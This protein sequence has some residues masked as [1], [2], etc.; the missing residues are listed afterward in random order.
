[1]E[2]WSDLSYKISKSMKGELL[3]V[4][5]ILLLLGCKRPY[6]ELFLQQNQIS[7]AQPRIQRANTIIDSFVI[8]KVDLG[9]EDADIYYTSDGSQPTTSSVKYKAPFKV[10]ENNTYKFRAFHANW[11]A[12]ET[13]TMTFYKKG[14]VPD[15]IIWFSKENMKYKGEGSLTLI[16][17]KKAAL[18]FNNPQWV[19]FDSIV[20]AKVVFKDK[21]MIKSIDIG[22]LSDPQSWIFPPS[23]I[24]VYIDDT[25]KSSDKITSQINEMLNMVPSEM[26]NINLE[27]NREVKSIRLEINNLQSIPKW[28]DGSGNRAWLFM[29]EWI[30][31]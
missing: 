7:L 2:F 6:Q 24:I 26:G 20:N 23:E 22:F 29:D 14:H 8:V 1:M 9:I 13:S 4:L 12:S 21:T 18:P 16:N 31:N 11:K 15:E 17:Q 5:I 10:T 25:D 19:G 28:H 30:F 3:W 27:I